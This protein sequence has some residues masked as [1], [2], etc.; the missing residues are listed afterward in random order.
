MTQSETKLGKKMSSDVSDFIISCSLNNIEKV[1]S[2]LNRGADVNMVSKDGLWS[3]LTIAA[4]KNYSE[5]VDLLL[6]QPDIKIN[7]TTDMGCSGGQWTALMFACDAGRP[8]IVSRLAGKEELDLNYQ[9]KWG[10]TAAH[11][12]SYHGQ[13]ECVRLLAETGMVD[14]NVRNKWGNV[15]IQKNFPVF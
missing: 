6:S 12:A 2:C 14:R 11:V 7:Q 9:D 3:G 1:R 10:R 4:R 13:T 8:G 5:L 15:A